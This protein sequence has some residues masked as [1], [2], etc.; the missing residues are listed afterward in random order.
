MLENYNVQILSSLEYCLKQVAY[1][2]IKQIK[3]IQGKVTD[4]PKIKII[5]Q[6]TLNVYYFM[7]QTGYHPVTVDNI[8][9]DK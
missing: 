3:A 9:S 2:I 5:I 7:I 4:T 8:F 1:K 6:Q